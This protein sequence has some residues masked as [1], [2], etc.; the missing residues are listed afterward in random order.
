MRAEVPDMPILVLSALA[1]PEV[2]KSFLREGALDYLVKLLT[3]PS[4]EN[5][6]DR[7]IKLFP[8]LAQREP[9][10]APA[11]ASGR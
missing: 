8:E 5:V 4:F 6:R 3:P 7:L 1:F 11:L 2:R 10:A 9:L